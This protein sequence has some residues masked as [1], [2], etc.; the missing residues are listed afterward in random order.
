M[1][2]LTLIL[3]ISAFAIF[4]CASVPHAHLDPGLF[5][6]STP[7]LT[8][9]SSPPVEIGTASFYHPALIGRRTASGARYSD[10]ALTAAHRTLEL[11]TRVRVTNLENSRS[12]IVTVNDRGPYA[13][14]R[15]ID[16]SRRAARALGFVHEG[17]ARVRVQPL[18]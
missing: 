15:I 2:A 13:H 7:T 1:K 14:G 4:G 3:A 12:V 17:L 18:T 6:S 5:E 11:G 16:L 9:E 8:P 10:K